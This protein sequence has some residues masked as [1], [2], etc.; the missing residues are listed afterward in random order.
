MKDL[1]FTITNTSPLILATGKNDSSYIDNQMDFDEFGFP[2][3]SARRFKG[4]LRHSAEQVYS[5]FE[6]SSMVYK[7]PTVLSVFG[8]GWSESKC[9]F[10]N[11]N[12]NKYEENKGFLNKLKLDNNFR[13]TSS[14]LI[15]AVTTIRN[16]TNIN[17]YGVTNENSL[18]AINVLN[19]GFQ[20]NGS[21]QFFDDNRI[22]ML[23]VLSLLNLRHIGLS[24]TRG[25]GNI[26]C[27]IDNSLSQK[28]LE[29]LSNGGK[30]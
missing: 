12:I 8:D 21:I 6:Q 28:C 23:I 30:I 9:V 15:N 2:F 22:E 17:S 10:S 11:I 13:F 14:D 16:Q 1:T 4:L 24:R 3:I 5:M 18:R 7:L 27:E 19:G 20:F 29:E 25:F 26:V